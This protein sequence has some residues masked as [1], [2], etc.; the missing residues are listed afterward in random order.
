MVLSAVL[1]RRLVRASSAAWLNSDSSS[2]TRSV[3]SSW[4]ATHPPPEIAVLMTS[5]IRPFFSREML[6]LLPS[7]AS[8]RRKSST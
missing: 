2:P 6:L 1:N 8:S 4:I 7:M 3:M 5:M